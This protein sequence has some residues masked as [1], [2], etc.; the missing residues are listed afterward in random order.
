LN[1]KLARSLLGQD[2]TVEKFVESILK[3]VTDRVATLGVSRQ[4]LVIRLAL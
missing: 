2:P 1:A 3:V 4:P